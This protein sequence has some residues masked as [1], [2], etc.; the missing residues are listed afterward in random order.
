MAIDFLI[1][2]LLLLSVSVNVLALGVFWMTPSLRTTAN[3]FV[4]NLLIV[5]L[6]CCLFLGPSLLLNSFDLRDSRDDSNDLSDALSDINCSSINGTAPGCTE[7]I[8]FKETSVSEIKNTIVI[9]E[10]EEKVKELDDEDDSI[11]PSN[12]LWTLD[13]AAALGAL[14]VLLVVGDTWCA[15]TDP[16][17]YHTRVSAPRAWALIGATWCLGIVFGV[18]SSFRGDDTVLYESY[19]IYGAVFSFAYFFV[20]ILLPFGL[21]CAMYWR[22]FREARENGL[23]MRQ[24]GSSPLLQ[25]A[26]NLTSFNT[27]QSPQNFPNERQSAPGDLP[28]RDGG[29]YDAKDSCTKPLLLKNNLEIPKSID[30]NQNNI[31]LSLSLESGESMR[32]NYSARQLFPHE[33]LDK[34]KC[35]LRHA[36]STPNLQ[37]LTTVVNV[38]GPLLPLPTVQVHPK[39]LSYM[40]SIR[41]RLSNAS[42]L[43]KYREESRAARISILVII[44][45]LISYIPFGILV[46]LEGHSVPLLSPSDRTLVSI[47]AVVLANLSSPFIFAYRNKRV[48]R[49]VRRLMSI[50]V[51]RNQRLQRRRNSTKTKTITLAAAATKADGKCSSNSTNTFVMEVEKCADFAV[52]QQKIYNQHNLHPPTHIPGFVPHSTP[53]RSSDVH[54]TSSEV[55]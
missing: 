29:E 45:F 22:I 18:A 40:T 31:L 3:R 52:D 38:S 11:L 14:S 36:N 27:Q 7:N 54:S 16:L 25:S 53:P 48:Q 13:V 4:I 46:L 49:G 19:G 42:S 55:V 47:F 50:N 26:L 24:N 34:L 17:R 28:P 37:K 35:D 23:R 20:I 2:A 43:F 51:K 41:H 30:S 39:A 1:G 21:V 6:V 44:M 5:N 15:V 8:I 33:D 10:F 9:T 32:R 12:R